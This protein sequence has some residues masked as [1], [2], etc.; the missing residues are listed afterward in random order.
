MKE[1]FSDSNN[2]YQNWNISF[3]IQIKIFGAQVWIFKFNKK[4]LNWNR[5]FYLDLEYEFWN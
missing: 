4:I 3:G 2:N 1:H 5:K